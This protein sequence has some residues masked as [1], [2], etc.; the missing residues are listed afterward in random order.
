MLVNLPHS[1][2]LLV[3]SKWIEFILVDLKMQLNI[4]DFAFIIAFI[5]GV[6][7]QWTLPHRT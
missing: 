4:I 2:R 6:C 3:L 5:D 1:G 7:G